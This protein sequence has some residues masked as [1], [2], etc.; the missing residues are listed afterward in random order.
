MARQGRSILLGDA[1]EMTDDLV[2]DLRGVM[3]SFC[4]RLYEKKSAQ[5]RRQEGARSDR[6]D[7]LARFPLPGAV[8]GDDRTGGVA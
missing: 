8:A 1:N 5:Q 6:M 2:C 7:K 4:A 3:V